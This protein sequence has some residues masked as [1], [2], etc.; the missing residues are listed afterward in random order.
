ME[1]RITLEKKWIGK[2]GPV[3]KSQNL[4][5]DPLWRAKPEE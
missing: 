1:G 5:T 3:F 2:T 4:G